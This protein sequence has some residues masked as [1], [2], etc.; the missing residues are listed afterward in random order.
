MYERDVAE[1][2]LELHIR[3]LEVEGL[4]G[5]AARSLGGVPL[6]VHHCTDRYQPILHAHKTSITDC[7]SLHRRVAV[8]PACT[9]NQHDGMA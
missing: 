1:S 7:P 4:H 6:A 3:Q 8:N 2:W 9:Q 5:A